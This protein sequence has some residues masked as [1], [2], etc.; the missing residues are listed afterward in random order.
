MGFGIDRKSSP[1]PSNM[2]KLLNE[3]R[4]EAGQT[5]S[6]EKVEVTEGKKDS[7][8]MNL[9]LVRLVRQL[10]NYIVTPKQD[11][12][13][14]ISAQDMKDV[15]PVYQMPL[16]EVKA[17]KTSEQ[18]TAYEAKHQGVENSPFS[19]NPEIHDGAVMII[20][21]PG[22][23][24]SAL[25]NGLIEKES[26]QTIKKKKKKKNAANEVNFKASTAASRPDGHKIGDHRVFELKPSQEIGGVWQPTAEACD[27]PK[28][29]NHASAC[30][31]CHKATETRFIANSAS[32]TYFLMPFRH[33]PKD[34]AGLPD[35]SLMRILL[36]WGKEKT[37]ELVGRHNGD[38]QKANVEARQMWLTIFNDTLK[39]E[40]GPDIRPLTLEQL[41][42]PMCKAEDMA[43]YMDL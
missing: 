11:V 38:M 25:I 36:S 6:G 20:G 41:T 17:L 14:F 7:W 3:A 13:P 30:I 8:F 33:L 19:Y 22:S 21:A 43:K 5:R 42:A 18:R 27:T 29:L 9:K 16:E 34:D 32:H 40:F 10:W 28:K 23:G 39:A 12:K 35:T 1:S 24:K 37:D 15:G 4:R 26:G 31:Y 2:T